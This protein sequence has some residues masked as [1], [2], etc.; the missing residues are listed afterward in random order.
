MTT[1]N[2][3]SKDIQA[4]LKEGNIRYYALRA[5]LKSRRYIILIV[6]YACETWV[7]TRKDE[8]TIPVWERK[9]S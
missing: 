2:V 1:D 8:L 5:V 4:R 6:T 9:V 3:V 7:L